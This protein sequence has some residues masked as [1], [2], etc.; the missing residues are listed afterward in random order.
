VAAA[1]QSGRSAQS[2]LT[3]RSLLTETDVRRFRAETP[4][5]GERIHFN[6]AGA[7][8]LPSPVLAAM[9]EYLELEAAA[10]GYEAA[11]AR[12]EQ[13]ADFYR[14]AAE[15][16]AC[17]PE[18]IAFTSSA[19]DSFA[20]AVSSIP[21]TRGDVI[22]T[23]RDDYASNQIAFIS[24]RRR[25]GVEVLHAP[26]RP[27]GGVDVT[28]LVRLMDRTGP[29]LVA[30]THIPTNSGLVQPVAA[31]GRHCRERDL[32]YLIDGCQSIGQY[33]LDV[34]RLGCDFLAATSRKFLRGARGSGLLYVSDR[35]LRAG[36]EPLFI[37]MRG[38]DWTGPTTYRPVAS[39]ARFEEWERSYAAVVGTA[40]AIRYALRIGLDA[41]NAR[42]V[43]LASHLRSLLAEIPRLRLLDH[44]PELCAIVTL[45]IDGLDPDDV[46]AQ[47]SARRIN[48]SVSDRTDALL[49]LTDKGVESCLRLSPHYYNTLDEVHEVAA[50]IAA[51]AA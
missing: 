31:I 28:E 2:P 12:Q 42:S 16:L 43:A 33:P 8:L 39:A 27:E 18:N 47:L 29:R 48:S 49:D 45:A 5:C 37:D 4:G 24:L 21:F 15:L 19:T 25:F 1:R 23:T 30:V 32:V 3:M 36:Y 22:L 51:V 44:G 50:A 34:T 40:A 14:A 9:T 11:A 35:A 26:N 20:R 41:I 46:H 38:A 7:G 6:N 10:G 17:R 13:I